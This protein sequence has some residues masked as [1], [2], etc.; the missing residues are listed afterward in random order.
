MLTIISKKRNRKASKWKNM[1]EWIFMQP[2][3]Q[4]PDGWRL[5]A[6][7][8]RLEAGGWRLS[9][10]GW[11]L[12][13]GGWRLGAGGWRLEAVVWRLEAGGWGPLP[14][15]FGGGFWGRLLGAACGLPPAACLPPAGYHSAG[16]WL[17]AI[18]LLACWLGIVWHAGHRFHPTAPSHSAPLRSAALAGDGRLTSVW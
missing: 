4:P 11:G 9:A 14:F 16:C 5:S 15:D 3:E 18:I 2:P 1:R 6:G 13:A 7:G 10:G 8:W 17:L 12:E